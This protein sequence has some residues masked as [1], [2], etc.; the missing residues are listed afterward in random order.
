MNDWMELDTPAK[1][2][3][4]AKQYCL[5]LEYQSYNDWYL[6]LASE[7]NM[8]Q[9]NMLELNSLDDTG[10]FRTEKYWSSSVDVMDEKYYAWVEDFSD[11]TQTTKDRDANW[12][13][14]RP[15]RRL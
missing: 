7:L 3:W 4:L 9:N 14:I 1:I 15:V 13:F 5:N 10:E 12:Y 11:G 6:P 8:M 2:W